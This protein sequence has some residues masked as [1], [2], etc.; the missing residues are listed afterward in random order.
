M[1]LARQKRKKLIRTEG[2]NYKKDRTEA[3]QRMA[4]SDDDDSMTQHW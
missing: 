3:E 4:R 1:S 2:N